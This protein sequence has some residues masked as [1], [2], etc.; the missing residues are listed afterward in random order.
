MKRRKKK[1][2][3]WRCTTNGWYV[4]VNL[5]TNNF[6]ITRIILHCKN[7]FVENTFPWHC[8]LLF[9]KKLLLNSSSLSVAIQFFFIMVNDICVKRA[10][11]LYFYKVGFSAWRPHLSRHA[12]KLLT[13]KH[14]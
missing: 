6:P 7:S 9:V 10:D 12:L 14:I 2:W 8:C 1:K 3:P 5:F 4:T 11:Q 13:Y